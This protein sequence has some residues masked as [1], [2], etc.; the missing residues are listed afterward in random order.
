MLVSRVVFSRRTWCAPQ[1]I[2][3][4][5]F[6]VLASW[7]CGNR[8]FS[9]DYT[10]VDAGGFLMAMLVIAWL[11]SSAV[12]LAYLLAMD[13]L[14]T[15]LPVSWWFLLTLAS[16]LWAFLTLI[17]ASIFAA[18]LDDIK[19]SDSPCDFEALEFAAVMGF[20]SMLAEIAV[21]VFAFL[22]FRKGTT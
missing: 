20:F 17:A 16:G 10:D 18:D 14:L 15:K 3:L 12:V 11:F 7:D 9:V 8:F 22:E 13:L 4:L 2:S 5:G 21:A 6:A 19:D 1:L